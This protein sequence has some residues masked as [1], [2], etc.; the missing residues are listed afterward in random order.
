MAMG[1]HVAMVSDCMATKSS[2]DH[3]HALKWFHLVFGGVVTSER[4]LALLAPGGS[5]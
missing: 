3:L 2:G 5:A 1:Y 4:A